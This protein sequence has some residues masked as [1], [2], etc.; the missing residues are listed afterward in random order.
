MKVSAA[1]LN[2]SWR[3][4]LTGWAQQLAELQLADGLWSCWIASCGAFG[5][6]AA[7]LVVANVAV[8]VSLADAASY[9]T[10]LMIDRA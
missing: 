5:V 3:T 8:V 9:A 10:L 4:N 1:R 7:A 6:P 2:G